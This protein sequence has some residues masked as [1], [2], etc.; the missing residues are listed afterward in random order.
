MSWIKQV[1]SLHRLAGV[2]L[3]A[4]AGF[5][6]YVP[7]PSQLQLQALADSFAF[8]A[9]E[10]DTEAFST[11]AQEPLFTERL[12]HFEIY[13][14]AFIPLGASLIDLNGDGH[15]NELCVT[16]AKRRL[17]RVM[18]VRGPKFPA[19][20]LEVPNLRRSIPTGCLPGDFNRDGVMDLL[21]Y[22]WG[23]TPIVYQAIPSAE[24]P[25]APGHFRPV[26]IVEPS[27]TWYT[28][29]VTSNDVDGDGQL[30][31]IIANYFHESA[32]VVDRDGD[33]G[34]AYMHKGFGNATN[35]AFNRL[36]LG[37]TPHN[38]D[39]RYVDAS[40]VF[41]QPDMTQWT[42][43]IGSV[44]MDDDGL[45]EIWFINDHGA[46]RL[47]HNRSQPG[48]PRF[49]LVKNPRTFTEPK[50]ISLGQ[51]DFHGMGLDFGDIN[52]DGLIDAVV[53]NFGADFTFHQSHYYWLNTGQ[54]ERFAANQA[55]F[56][57][58][59]ESLGTS[60]TGGV[61]WDVRVGDFNNDSYPEFIKAVGFVRGSQKNKVTEFHEVALM[62]D[63]AMQFPE[64][65]HKFHRAMT[66]P[67]TIPTP[68][69]L[70]ARPENTTTSDTSSAFGRHRSLAAFPQ[71][72]ST[73]TVASTLRCPTKT[74]VQ[75][76]T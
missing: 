44:D 67:E 24:G 7:K 62:N 34:E 54:F 18:P 66:S 11:A 29:S 53:T 14:N 57:D 47:Y 35:G 16:N 28:H 22:F 32:K 58:I 33:P 25:L 21:V 49:T 64:A 19:F 48:T 63:Y 13:L 17:I 23:R 51:D 37:T 61:P 74:A 38:G 26:E 40:E 59:G 31:L 76:F 2:L 4:A 43:A 65:W 27:G 70:E 60:R 69:S 42:I 55:P 50:S 5:L 75:R 30:D 3:I 73:P 41:Q 45:P 6:V 20:S 56:R 1:L 8:V 39:A 72:T 15:P 52:N 68:S 12:Q 10:L 71:P 9:T 36:L 46:D